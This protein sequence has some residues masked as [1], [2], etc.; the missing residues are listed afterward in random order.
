MKYLLIFLCSF[1]IPVFHGG[2][3][4]EYYI[5]LDGQN[6]NL[7]FM[8]EKGELMNFEFKEECDIKGMTALCTIQY[9]NKHSSILIND[10]K[11]EFE[12]QN[13]YSEGDHLI[14]L[15]HSKWTGDVIK[16][17]AVQ[18]KCFYE[19]DHDFKNRIILDVGKFQ[20]SYLL[21]QKQDKIELH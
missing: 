13:S 17:I 18:N 9:L 11:I 5:Q 7:K 20:K 19:F 4:A 10:K 1:T 21:N 3:V 16:E 6:L 8:I 2:H 15:M 12:F 14:I